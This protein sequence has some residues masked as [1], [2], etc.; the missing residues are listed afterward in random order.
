MQKLE[1]KSLNEYLKKNGLPEKL[2]VSFADMNKS[3][4][5]YKNNTIED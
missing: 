3:Y 4:L 1:K 5:N 2:G